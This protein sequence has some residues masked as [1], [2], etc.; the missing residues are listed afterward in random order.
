MP[1]VNWREFEKDVK[2]GRKFIKPIMGTAKNH[3]A[4]Y[5]KLDADLLEKYFWI[6]KIP[7]LPPQI[8]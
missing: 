6:L 5:D 1:G 7:G 3:Q 2:D 4:D 8:L